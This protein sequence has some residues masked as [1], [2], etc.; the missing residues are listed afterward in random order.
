MNSTK[1]T[2]STTD[3]AKIVAQTGADPKTVRRAFQRKPG[4]GETRRRVD[5]ALKAMG[6]VASLLLALAP[7]LARADACPWTTEDMDCQPADT[8]SA[9][10]IAYHEAK[11]EAALRL[12]GCSDGSGPCVVLP[13]PL[14]V[15]LPE[16]ALV[17]MPWI[18]YQPSVG[19]L[20]DPFYDAADPWDGE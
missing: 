19:A 3:I 13:A 16:W 15:E 14:A 2:I 18:A 12:A 4:K 6:L 11:A 17:P 8:M 10:D 7:S 1:K 5:A 9:E 20:A